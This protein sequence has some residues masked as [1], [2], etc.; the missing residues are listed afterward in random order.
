MSSRKVLQVEGGKAT[1]VTR[2][3]L[4][5][6]YKTQ[7]KLITLFDD[8]P[9]PIEKCYIRLVLLTQH[10]FQERKKQ[11]TSKNRSSEEEQGKDCRQI[12]NEE[13]R[14]WPDTLDYS[15]IYS[16][17]QETI[18]L[19]D[20]WKI[21]GE[22][23]EPEVRHISIRGEA[24]TGKSVLTQRIAY[25]WANKQMWND[26]FQWLLHIPLRKIANI[27]EKTKEQK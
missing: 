19:D 17:V 21:K 5:D 23:G 7:D 11:M 13:D 15:L 18:E 8:P 9:Q 1:E 26:Q 12:R 24:G 25:L 20:I 10:Q 14:K 6:Y 16:G 22:D 4:K 2:Q 27:F 3:K